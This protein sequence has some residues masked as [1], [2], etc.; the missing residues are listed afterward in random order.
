MSAWNE[1]FW[2][3]D[4]RVLRNK[5]GLR[6]RADLRAAEHAAVARRTAQIVDGTVLIDHS[7]DAT[8]LRAIHHHLFQDVYEW[9]G[10]FRTV[11]MARGDSPD[12]V[13][14]GAIQDELAAATEVIVS[15]PWATLDLEVFCDALAGVAAAINFAHP[16]RDGNGR[17]SKVFLEHVAEESS[18][19]LRYSRV[20]PPE[21]NYA[22]EL[23]MP[24]GR[25]LRPFPTP[26]RALIE[27]LAQPEESP[28]VELATRVFDI[29]YFPAAETPIGIDL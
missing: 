18:F 7:Y 19:V 10:D 22:F 5:L 13:S 6:D 25:E 2:D 12:F 15:T 8:H 17:A 14:L 24:H 27:R 11:N 23:S 20:T 16:F 21:W 9:A 26:L 3:S 1:Y 28:G 4:T 29:T